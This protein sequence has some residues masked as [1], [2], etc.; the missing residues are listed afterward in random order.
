MN[1]T[2]K[3]TKLTILPRATQTDRFTILVGPNK[4]AYEV[5]EGLLNMR[6]I[7]FERMCSA[8]FLE[9][10][11]RVINLPEEEPENFDCFFD[12]IYSLR[13]HVGFGNGAEAVF[14]LAIF[15]E[16]YLVCHLKN[17]LQISSRKLG[18]SRNSIPK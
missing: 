11:Q 2:K 15:A 5:P 9:S 12:W 13:P 8:P 10:T 3:K 16:K 14:N 17:Q 1:V 18:T 4:S 6:S 7:V